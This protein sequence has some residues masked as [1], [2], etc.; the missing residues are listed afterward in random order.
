MFGVCGDVMINRILDWLIKVVNAVADWL[1]EHFGLETLEE[2]ERG[3]CDCLTPKHLAVI[4]GRLFCGY[5]HRL[6][7]S[8]WGSK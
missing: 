5:C 7:P 8:E 6:R 4:E 2:D 1:H 3:Q